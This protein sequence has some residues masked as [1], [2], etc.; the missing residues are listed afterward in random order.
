MGTS[1]KPMAFDTGGGKKS[2]S[3]MLGLWPKALNTLSN[4]YMLKS[5]SLVYSIG[6]SVLRQGIGFRWESGELLFLVPPEVP[7]HVERAGVPGDCGD[8]FRY[9]G[10]C[11]E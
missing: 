11:Q 9:A 5:C 4:M 10:F 1:V 7:C 6:Q 3:E 8:S 2:T